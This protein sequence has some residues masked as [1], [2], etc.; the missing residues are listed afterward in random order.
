MKRNVS[1][2]LLSAAMV[3]GTLLITVSATA[4]T[5]NEACPDGQLA[6]G[7]DGQ[8]NLICASADSCPCWDY[9]SALSV[10]EEYIYADPLQQVRNPSEAGCEFG[11]TGGRYLG[12]NSPNDDGYGE[13][14]VD[15][16]TS[17]NISWCLFRA[18]GPQGPFLDSDRPNR[19]PPF[20]FSVDFGSE[21][22]ALPIAP[23]A[24]R[25]C[26]AIFMAVAEETGCPNV[27][28]P[29]FPLMDWEEP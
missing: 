29:I 19:F 8:G 12:S 4:K 11:P 1:K 28:H 3:V 2:I 25:A 13:L 17:G 21:V 22:Q 18:E 7:L 27:E 24:A 10:L 9:E 23:H 5:K 16:T 14:W 20:L 26:L 6:M 15:R